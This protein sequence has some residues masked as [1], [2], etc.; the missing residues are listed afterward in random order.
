[1]T[2]APSLRQAASP[3]LLGQDTGPDGLAQPRRFWAMLAVLAAVAMA[4]LDI[5]I[6]NM[7]L[8][9]ISRDLN[10]SAGLSVWVIL[11]YQLVMVATILPFAALGEIAG[12]SRVYLFGI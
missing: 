10:V 5:A 4:T 3:S 9:I 6:A 1:M 11:S 2:I 8:P 12:H 7:A